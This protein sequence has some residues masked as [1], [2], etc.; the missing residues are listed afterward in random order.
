M[1]ARNSVPG[2]TRVFVEPR[3][4]GPGTVRVFPMF[5]GLYPATGGIAGPGPIA[6]VAGSTWA[7]R[8]DSSRTWSMASS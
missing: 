7:S 5:D 1:W 8:P 2:V 4:G 3:F 6:A